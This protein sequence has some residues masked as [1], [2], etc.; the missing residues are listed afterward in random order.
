MW[1]TIDV[2]EVTDMNFDVKWHQTPQLEY[3][4]YIDSFIKFAKGRNATAFVLGSFA[5]KYPNIV[6]KLADNGI[7]IA[8]HGLHHNLVYKEDFEVWKEELIEAKK[9]LENLISKPVLGYRSPSWSMPFEKEYY[10][11]LAEAGFRYSS[12]YFPMKNYMYGN[13]I[14]KKSPFYIYTKYGK[15]QERP[16][17]K[18]VIPFS[19]GFYLRVLPLWLLKVVFGKTE[20]PVL[21]IHPYELMEMNLL[22]YFKRYASFNLDYFLAF[23]ASSPA[24]KKIEAL[25]DEK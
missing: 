8:C 15:V 20:N 5:Q 14:N 7:E 24:K 2:E 21:Y 1:L 11:A 18:K 22:R 4:K 12:S 9:I 25:L 6:K 16:I 23:Y 17:A 19:G 3:E 13:S 10:E